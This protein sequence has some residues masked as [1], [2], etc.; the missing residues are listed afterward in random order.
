MSWYPII[1]FM[2]VGF[3]LPMATSVP[4]GYGHNISAASYIDAGIEVTQPEQWSDNDT[5]RLKRPF[6][7]V[8]KEP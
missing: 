5:V 6:T 2:Q 4:D 1:T 7:A 8:S 3:D